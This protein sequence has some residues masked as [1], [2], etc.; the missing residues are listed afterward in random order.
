MNI[1][2]TGL[3]VAA[4]L[5]SNY[6]AFSDLTTVALYSVVMAGCYATTWFLNLCTSGT[7]LTIQPQQA[8]VL[9]FL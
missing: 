8:E 1:L 5:L 6:L 9:R 4:F 2:R 3:V 7:S